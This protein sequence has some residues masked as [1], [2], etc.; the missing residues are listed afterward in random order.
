MHEEYKNSSCNLKGK[1]ESLDDREN[2]RRM[3]ASILLKKETSVSFHKQPCKHVNAFQTTKWNANPVHHSLYNMRRFYS[4]LVDPCQALQSLWNMTVKGW[5]RHE[6]YA[7][8]F[9]HLGFDRYRSIEFRPI[10][11]NYVITFSYHF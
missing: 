1:Q 3:A 11:R 7:L 9:K 8:E 2:I 4:L 10:F 6:L 5:N